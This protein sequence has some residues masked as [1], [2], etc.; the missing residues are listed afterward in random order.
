MK[1]VLM[2]TIPLI[3]LGIIVI[4]LLCIYAN[5]K[6]NNPNSNPLPADSETPSTN[7]QSSPATGN[8]CT[9]LGC[10]INA[11]YVGSINSDKYYVCDCRYAKNINPENIICFDSDEDALS[12][13]YTK[14]E[15]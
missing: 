5:N 4:I 7:N 6:Y 15:C 11:E 13:N 10:S 12:K 14:V 1:K 2:I 8:S 9:Q 3:L